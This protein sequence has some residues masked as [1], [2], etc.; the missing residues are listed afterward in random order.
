MPAFDPYHRWLGIPS[1]EQPPNHYRLLSLPLFESDLDVIETAVER[2]TVFLRTF[3]IGPQAELAERILNE[4][5]RAQVT[6][7]NVDQK[8]AYD[9]KLR[10]SLRSPANPTPPS[11][12]ATLSAEVDRLRK[13]LEQ[14]DRELQERDQD[15]EQE[16]AELAHQQQRL[17]QEAA[18]R[19]KEQDQQGALEYDE[20]EFPTSTYPIDPRPSTRRRSPSRRLSGIRTS[21]SFLSR[22][23]PW[24][25]SP[26][27]TIVFV[28]VAGVFSLLALFLIL[29]VSRW[30]ETDPTAAPSLPANLT[31][32]LVAYYPFN[33]NA[34]DESGNGNH[35]VSQM[36]PPS[37]PTDHGRNNG[38]AYGFDGNDPISLTMGSECLPQRVSLSG[39][40]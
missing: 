27:P 17:E 5:A 9:N 4:V 22:I 6:L 28:V 34:R 23:L 16:R 38:R 18:S 12:A 35:P 29:G 40:P 15:L 33:G 20:A 26:S 25:R 11:D 13:K 39:L 19:K 3:Q 10:E 21:K 7:L 1:G 14:R 2:Q 37:L 30:K 24:S 36:T 8:I 31:E 32:G